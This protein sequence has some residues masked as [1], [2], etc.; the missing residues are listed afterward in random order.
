MNNI[1]AHNTKAKKN[2][3]TRWLGTDGVCEHQLV[4]CIYDNG[5]QTFHALPP[6]THIINAYI[7]RERLD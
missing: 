3:E 1:G 4:V 7:F 2:Y 5:V 6:P